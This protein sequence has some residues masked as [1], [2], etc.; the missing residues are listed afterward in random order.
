MPAR[1]R[2]RV[3]MS[4]PVIVVGVLTSLSVWAQG[5]PDEGWLKAPPVQ[6]QPP[7]PVAEPLLPRPPAPVWPTAMSRPRIVET[8]NRVS[9]FGAPALGQWQRGQSLVLGFP[10]LSVRLSLGVLEAL[11]VGLGFDSFYGAMNEPKLGA[12]YQLGQGE[13]WSAAASLEA[14]VAFFNQRAAREFRG[15]RWITGHRNFNLAPGLI[16]TYQAPPARA[17]RLFF[18]AR[19]LLAFDTEPFATDP[20]GGV[21]A[22]VKLGHNV[23]V[24]AGAELPLSERTS[25][26]FGL[27]LDVHG[28]AEDAALMPGISLGLVT[29][30]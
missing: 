3:F 20:L 26:V 24:R 1:D 9:M 19:Y 22:A 14:G 6:S 16:V 4:R 12:K 11:D 13:R 10:L 21:P 18:E 28:R 29:G 23:V 15:P 5:A 25:F 27:G 30:L 2:L 17:A 8:P 7:T